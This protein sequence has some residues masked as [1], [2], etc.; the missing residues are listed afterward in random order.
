MKNQT[1]ILRV[2][3]GTKANLETT[4]EGWQGELVMATDAGNEGRLLICPANETGFV[5]PVGGVT[6]PSITGSRNGNVA[7]ANL[8]D[9]LE[10]L[11]IITNNTTA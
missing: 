3:T 8:L 7:L 9:A 2:G 11:G 5:S 10:T 6:P 4:I 1:V